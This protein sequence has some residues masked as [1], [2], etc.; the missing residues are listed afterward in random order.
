[1]LSKVKSLEG[2][3]QNLDIIF[4]SYRESNS[5]KN[6]LELKKRFPRAKRVHGVAGILEAHQMAAEKSETDFFFVVDGDNRIRPEFEFVPPQNLKKDTLYVWR[7]YNPVN[8]LVYGYGAIKLYNKE[9]L[10]K[11]KAQYVDLATTVSE[12]Y[13]IIHEIAS[14]TYFHSTS[15]EAWR[16]AFRECAKL[17]SQI[18]RKGSDPESEQRLEA[19]CNKQNAFEHAQWVKRGAQAGRS[20]GESSSSD[21]SLINDFQKLGEEF[22]RYK[23]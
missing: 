17:S 8:E 20:F 14:E 5:D 2:G 21:L 13:H 12:K 9:L 6:W 4:I 22:A 10:L 19:W 7:C 1:M 18:K 11:R 16:G 15:L 23:N 3:L